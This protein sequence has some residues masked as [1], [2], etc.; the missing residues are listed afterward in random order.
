NRISIEEYYESRAKKID[1]STKDK[2]AVVYAEGTIMDG[3]KGEPGNIYDAQYVKILRKVRQDD[4]VKAIV[5]RI[6]SPGG[7]V[8]ASENILREVLLC[9]EAGKP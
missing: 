3:E 9:K 4:G 5:L 6:N 1:F 8:L 7:S 2:I